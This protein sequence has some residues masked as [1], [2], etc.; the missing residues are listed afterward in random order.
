MRFRELRFGL[1]VF[2][3]S[4]ALLLVRF[5]VPRP[6][7]MADN[8][9]GWRLLCK[10][11]AQEFDRPSEDF[12][13]FG[14]GAAPPCD[15][16]YVSSQSWFDWAATKLGE[17]F[18]V[19]GVLNLIVLGVLTCVLVAA[20]IT[21]TVLGLDLRGWHR[22]LATALLLLVMGDS[23]F[24]GYFASVLSEGAAFL[25]ILLICGGL[26]LMH[27]RLGLRR[28]GAVV[29][30]LGGLIGLN[31]KS[32][33]LVLIPLFVLAVL[34]V[35]PPG[36]RGRARWALPVVVLAI[37][38]AGTFAMQSQGDPANAEYRQ[39]NMYN[40]IFN[41]IVDG[42]HDTKGDLAAL[43]LPGS[44]EKYVGTGWWS[45]NG[46]KHDPSYPQY[47]DRISRRNVADYYASHPARVAQIL[48]QGG[49]NT[50]TARPGN[51]GSFGE[52]SG[53]PPLA[54]E[55]RV[56]VFSGLSA[57]AA[58]LGL[59]VL[60][61]L[62]ALVA[63]A[64]VRAFRHRRREYGIVLFLLLFFAVGQLGLSAL[65]EGIEGVKH[66]LLTL[67]PTVLAIVFGILSLLPRAGAADGPEPAGEPRAE[68]LPV[69]R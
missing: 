48:Q 59:F 3:A 64:G 69:A 20:A 18:G 4:L 24:F 5:L 9:D 32:Q 54:K 65:G 36:A 28:T 12:V 35:R 6:V 45:A 30:V 17:L 68:V 63:W 22:V 62:W 11:G 19:A 41:S 37:V 52:L 33:T 60:V 55:Y 13:R 1:A 14:Y 56:P 10:L 58:P 26:L 7:G 46:A 50:L 40:A 67:F 66:Q 16:A 47:E 21:L 34:L 61:P 39:A 29:T 2:T 23:A 27:R 51:L 42:K 53:Q 15:S 25:G 43:G 49:V 31:A 57:L 44:F 38:G 8:G